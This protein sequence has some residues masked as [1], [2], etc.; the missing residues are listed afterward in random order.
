MSKSNVDLAKVPITRQRRTKDAVRVLRRPSKTFGERRTIEIVV[1]PHSQDAQ[2]HRNNVAIDLDE[3]LVLK[4]LSGHYQSVRITPIRTRNDLVRLAE[5]RPDLVFS[6]VKYFTFDGENLWLSDFLDLHEIAYIASG[7]SA[8]EKEHDKAN[9]KRIVLRA[10]V[11]SAEFFVAAPEDHN[12]AASLPLPF[13]L[14]VKPVIG[15]DS[16]GVDANSVVHDFESFQRKVLEIRD[17]QMSRSIAET[18]LSGRE[19]SVGILENIG[20]GTLRAMPIEIVA[21]PNRNGDRI[22]DFDVKK[23]DLETVAPVTD[24]ALRRQLCIAATAAFR[25]L[26]GRMLGRIDFKMDHENVPH[27]I[28][29]N[30]MPGL[31]KGYFYRSCLLNLGMSYEAM[32]LTIAEN[33]LT[34]NVAATGHSRTGFRG[35]E[36]TAKA[37]RFDYAKVE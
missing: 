33:G 7:R 4:I 10:D 13:P 32:I 37:A 17:N 12:S 27:F 22:L 5:R 28:E 23:Q 11:A 31:R 6:G 25:A 1:A 16:R 26:G 3:A 8:L 29:A 36:L 34:S 21:A 24:D 19:Y 18:Y 35:E 15:G 2:V 30:L 14:F 9:A 20:T